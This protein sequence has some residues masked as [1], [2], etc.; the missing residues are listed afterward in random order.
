MR[1]LAAGAID[2]SPIFNRTLS[3]DGTPDGYRAMDQREAIKICLN[4]SAP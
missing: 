3:L 2:P 1:A 4:V